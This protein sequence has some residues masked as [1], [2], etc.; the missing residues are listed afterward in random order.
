[1]TNNTA[2]LLLIFNRPLLSNRVFEAIKKAT[3]PKLF[4]AAD[5]PRE[6]KNEEQ[7]CAEA[8]LISSKVDWPC[9]VYTLFRDTNL[10]SGIAVSQAINWF[11]E[12]VDQG[13]ILEDDCLPDLSFFRFCE[14]LLI[15]YA[16]TKEVMVISGTNLLPDGWKKEKQSYH[17]GHGGVWGWA[18]WKR[19]WNLYDYS[20][21]D[22]KKPGN[23]EKIKRAMK[24]VNW[25]NYYCGMFEGASHQPPDVWDLQWLHGVF[26]NGG[27]CINPS[28]NLVKNIGFGPG[29][30]HTTEIEGPYVNLVTQSMEFPLKHPAKMVVD[31]RY[32]RITFWSVFKYN[33]SFARTV[34]SGAR[35]YLKRW[36]LVKN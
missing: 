16:D 9:E 10:G 12:K 36:G 22:W 5:G 21:P 31:K 11:F 13:I 1:M 19:A 6:G 29:A 28:V 20:M 2:V 24:N 35:L 33:K 32:L 17:F 26:N 34:K 7:R 23:P 14:D 3:P 25:Y 4:I 15:K 27:L 18:T 8:R 30:T